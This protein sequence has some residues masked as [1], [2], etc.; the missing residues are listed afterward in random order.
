MGDKLT[1]A[2]IV[3][4]SM[5]YSTFFN[6][7]APGREYTLAILEKFPVLLV[8]LKGLGEDFKE[9]LATRRQLDH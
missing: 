1:L 3:L 7:K 2:D 9:Y 8:Y 5:A 4:A 6:E